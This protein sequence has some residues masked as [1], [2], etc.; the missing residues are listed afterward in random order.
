MITKIKRFKYN[1]IALI[2]VIS[3]FAVTLVMMK[4]FGSTKEVDYFFS[5]ILVLMNLNVLVGFIYSSFFQH[6]LKLKNTNI[7]KSVN[8][9]KITLFLS[10]IISIIVL[11]LYKTISFFTIDDNFVF[12][13]FTDMYI[14]IILFLG[15]FEI[16]NFLINA[17]KYYILPYL[18]LIFLNLINFFS[19]FFF[20][21]Y[22]L[23]VIIYSTILGYFVCLMVQ[24]YLIYKHVNLSYK[25]IFDGVYIK[26][27]I[28]D[29]FTIKL[30]SVINGSTD[31]VIAYIFTSFG[32]GFYAI[33]SYARKFAL[34]VYNISNG[35]I[36]KKFNTEIA[37]LIL[38]KDYNLIVKKA[39][40][41]VLE[42]FPLFI[43]GVITVYTLL[44]YGLPFLTSKFTLSDI[45]LMK[46][47]FIYLSVFYL[48]LIIEYILMTIISQFHA[49]KYGLWI[50]IFYAIL[51]VLISTTIFYFN[52]G[53]EV[54]L[55]ALIFSLAINLFSEYLII[56]YKLFK[57]IYK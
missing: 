15:L 46:S 7:G 45:V 21:K 12:N 57:G 31:I 29:S 35:P 20:H 53:Y 4:Y 28:K 25:F 18:F 40:K 24:F 38:S 48:F 55:L 22:G 43:I 8:Y 6:Y 17:H 23:E 44:D 10:L 51:F 56:K 42:V 14:Y 3:G 19:L 9:Y 34:A 5:S 54:V 26:N 27:T 41:I 2:N 1:I 13:E 52:L 36:I 50:N 39:N 47:I 49:F 33:Y 16:N 32:E 37:P 30:S 11:L